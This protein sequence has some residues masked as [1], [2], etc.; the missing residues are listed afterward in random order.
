MNNK[1]DGNWDPFI[2]LLGV[3]IK[4]IAIG[5]WEL[6]KVIVK[7]TPPVIKETR[8]SAKEIYRILAEEL[9]KELE[10][11]ARAEEERA[12]KKEKEEKKKKSL[13]ELKAKN[14]AIMHQE[15]V[16]KAMAGAAEEQTKLGEIYEYGQGVEKNQKSAVKWYMKAA[17]QGNA[18]ALN[19]LGEAY[20]D[21]F[22][23][24]DIPQSDEL[25]LK[26]FKRAA[27]KGNAEAMYN[28]GQ[29]H[30]D[31]AFRGCGTV[32]V[33]KEEAFEWFKKAA[34]LGHADAQNHVGVHY[35]RGD[36]VTQ[37]DYEAFR[38]YK[39]SAEQGNENGCH[40]LSGI[41]S[42]VQ[43]IVQAEDEKST[44]LQIFIQD[45]HIED[46]IHFTRFENL[47]SILEN[48][49][50]TRES[51]ITLNRDAYV[52]DSLRLD[53]RENS[54]S[55]SI[56]FPN[57]KMFYKYRMSSEAKGWVVIAIKPEVLWQYRSA[58]CK[59]NAADAKISR[60]NIDELCTL[61][62]FEEMFSDQPEGER[63]KQRLNL[64]DPTDP[65]AEV[66][67]F[68]DIPIKHITAVGFEDEALLENFK[69]N[70]VQGQHDKISFVMSKDHF[71]SRDH[72]R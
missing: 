60:R 70:H 23:W 20:S 55:L 52:N 19:K 67:V 25:A 71:K 50:V 6:C 61:K 68:G 59:H 16:S 32:G 28:L 21:P 8:K 11:E 12:L 42:K 34:V 2:E 17:D 37:N 49:I 29:M 69:A 27:Q 51:I 63:E 45:R 35:A 38:W 44:K 47:E 31:N 3:I 30:S 39:K 33:N 54:V 46:L 5:V 57:H 24:T 7:G 9:P 26:W 56:S 15:L 66:L 22:S 48:G 53:R 62:E 64:Y 4:A 18:E 36:V 41:S 40:N 14:E 1:R 58:F 13:Q 72:V 65:Q 10:K 43:E